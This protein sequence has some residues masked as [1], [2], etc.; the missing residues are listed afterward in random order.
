M[1]PDYDIHKHIWTSYGM[2]YRYVDHILVCGGGH[3]SMI[4]VP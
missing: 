2:T 3:S 4:D 1:F